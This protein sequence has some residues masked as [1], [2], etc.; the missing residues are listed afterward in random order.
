MKKITINE[1]K[2]DN[3]I[4]NIPIVK[5]NMQGV[6]GTELK[7]SEYNYIIDILDSNSPRL[8][9]AMKNIDDV[10]CCEK[11]VEEKLVKALLS[12]LGY[13]ENDYV[14]Q[15]Y[16]PIGNNNNLLIPD[17]VLSPKKNGDYYTCFAVIETKFQIE[18]QRK[19]NKARLQARS[20]SKQLSA[21]FSVIAS[22]ENIWIY[23]I[24][25]DYMKCIYKESWSNLGQIDSFREIKKILEKR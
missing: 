11:D 13:K 17:F 2:N 21:T 16:I 7:P 18:N 1:M 12:K 8:E 6:N 23:S 9:N 5:K 25:D 4:K 22:K 10:F 24:N 15:L 14:R 20:Y 3:I 19:L